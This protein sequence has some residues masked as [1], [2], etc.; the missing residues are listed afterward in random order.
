MS[1]N[2]QGEVV[3]ATDLCSEWVSDTG[4][5]AF[6]DDQADKA[7]R[8]HQTRRLFID[9]NASTEW[10][11]HFTDETLTTQIVGSKRLS[12]FRLNK[13]NWPLYAEAIARNL[14]HFPDRHL[15]FPKEPALFK[16]DGILQPG[17]ALYLPPFWWRGVDPADGQ[18]G[19]TLAH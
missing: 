5:Y 7:P 16:F 4:R 14:H 8:M 17:D 9:K 1:N 19:I 3:P 11:C 15:H 13:E 12:A 2:A 18:F 10:H 6:L